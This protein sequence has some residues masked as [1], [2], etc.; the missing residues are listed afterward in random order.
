MLS[1]V[2]TEVTSVAQD[3]PVRE[4][5]GRIMTRSQVVERIISINPT[6]SVEFLAR[7]Q[8]RALRGYLEHLH[9]VQEP[10]GR[11]TARW[12]RPADSPAIMS[13]SPRD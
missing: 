5:Q 8:D 2:E 10:R 1:E 13:R 6:A 9:A 7:F 3:A 4:G 11:A 12:V